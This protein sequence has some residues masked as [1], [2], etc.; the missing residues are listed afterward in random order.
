MLE[1]SHCY[2][3]L[4]VFVINT[5][6]ISCFC[7]QLIEYILPYTPLT[8]TLQVTN[9]ICSWKLRQFNGRQ[10]INMKQSLTQVFLSLRYLCLD[11][12]IVMGKDEVNLSLHVSTLPQPHGQLIGP[13]HF[14]TR[15]KAQASTVQATEMV[16]LPVWSLQTRGKSLPIR[17]WTPGHPAHSLV[18]YWLSFTLFGLQ[19]II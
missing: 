16:P 14:T 3:F 15:K 9:E 5:I 2:Y 19:Q 17:N 7:V 6:C 11:E 18:T 8:V 13:S 1:Q 10:K 4:W 12:R